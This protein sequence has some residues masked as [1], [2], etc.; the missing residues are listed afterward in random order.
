MG[1]FAWVVVLMAVAGTASAQTPVEFGAPVLTIG[2]LDAGEDAA[3]VSV[4]G[5]VLER[6]GGVVIADASTA[7]VRWF[8][9]SGTFVRATGGVGDGPGEYR[10]IWSV[11]PYRGDS[12][13]VADQL[14]LTVT[15]LSS[16][17]QFGRRNRIEADWRDR[18]AY[19]LSDL[20]HVI[21]SLADGSF[22]LEGPPYM[23]VEV[24][25]GP[26]HATQDLFLLGPEGSELAHL[27]TFWSREVVVEQAGGRQQRRYVQFSAP[28]RRDA[29]G[30][31][32]A[33]AGPADS[34]RFVDRTGQ[35]RTLVVVPDGPPVEPRH[36]RAV[37]SSS[38]EAGSSAPRPVR[39][40]FPG[41]IDLVISREGNLWL[42]GPLIPGEERRIWTAY[43]ASGELLGRYS[44][45][46][47]FRLFDVAGSRVAGVL[48]GEFDVES[49]VVF[50]TGN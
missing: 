4:T 15:V 37:T 20:P 26:Q 17:G 10:R 34:L 31:V 41:F 42:G 12:I 48:T 35:V 50:E 2:G 44:A 13:Y 47:T 22:V 9:S 24:E 7:E 25:P 5:V 46:R 18:S 11:E 3:F 28:F 33:V 16:D 1:R 29:Q 23:P 14:G 40:R 45:P 30:A 36:V 39:D 27:G 19:P 43:S 32:I 6:D 38:P 49:V 21:G 8:D